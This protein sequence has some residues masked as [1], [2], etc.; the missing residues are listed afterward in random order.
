MKELKCVY[1]DWSEIAK[2]YGIEDNEDDTLVV[3]QIREKLKLIILDL[4]DSGKAQSEE[5]I[6]QI[7]QLKNFIKSIAL[8]DVGYSGPIWL[9]LTSIED[10]FTFI[11]FFSPLIEHLWV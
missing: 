1:G 7:D 5:I 10:D 2:W 11:Q 8:A 3:E 6:F 4:D 9:G